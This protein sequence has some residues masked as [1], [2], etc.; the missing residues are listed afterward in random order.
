MLYYRFPGE[1]IVRVNG[2][3][4]EV[5]SFDIQGFIITD[6]NQKKKYVFKEAAPSKASQAALPFCIDEAAYLKQATQL[7]KDLNRGIADK[8]VLIKYQKLPSV[9]NLM[10]SWTFI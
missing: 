7:I 6:F 8:I 10:K 4:I 2:D 3:F 9:L 5:D 1:E